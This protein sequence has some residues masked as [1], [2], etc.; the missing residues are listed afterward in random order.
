MSDHIPEPLQPV[1]SGLSCILARSRRQ[2]ME[3]SL[4]LA[5]QGIHSTI[6]HTPE[7]G[8]TLEVPHQDSAR[9]FQNLRQY[10]IE[11]RPSVWRDTFHWP[12]VRWD[13]TSL[14]WALLL[15]GFH[16][17]ASANPLMRSVGLMEGN[18]LSTGQWWRLFTAILLHENL[19]H[20]AAN[21]STGIVLLGLAM[22]R[23]GAGPALLA[24]FVCGALGNL[25]SLL[26]HG[27][28]FLGLGASGM[29]M[30]ALGLLAAQSIVLLHRTSHPIATTREAAPPPFDRSRFRQIATGLAASL[31]LFVLFGLSPGS[32]IAAHLGGFVSGAAIGALLV[33]VPPST[34]R[35]SS[36]NIPA[37]IAFLALIAVTWLLALK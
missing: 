24:A 20:L 6:S 30:G 35:R 17:V 18:A 3:W 9:A 5:S 34:L 33:F 7:S 26:V 1:N 32:D 4:V 2:A 37:S 14:A 25:F 16:W 13:W 36:V 21:I 11:N 29:V 10:R 15:I 12:D 27:P 22:G 23:F 8:W 19:A 31:M 28:R